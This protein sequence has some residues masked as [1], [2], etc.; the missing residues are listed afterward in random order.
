M[1]TDLTEHLQTE[2]KVETPIFK[3]NICDVAFAWKSLLKRHR[4]SKHSKTEPHQ[5]K[6]CKQ[7]RC[8]H[9]VITPTKDYLFTAS[10]DRLSSEK[11]KSKLNSEASKAKAKLTKKKKKKKKREKGKKTPKKKKKKKKK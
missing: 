10:K 6:T 5:C 3:C 8:K 4:A 7:K 11:A 1:G 9:M 2:H